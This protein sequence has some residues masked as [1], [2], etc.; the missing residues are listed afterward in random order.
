MSIPVLVSLYIFPPATI[1]SLLILLSIHSITLY[2]K[3]TYGEV[4]AGSPRHYSL[5]NC[6]VV[7]HSSS[8]PYPPR[9]LLKSSCEPAQI[10]LS[11]ALLEPF[12]IF[13]EEGIPYVYRTN[14]PYLP[15][16]Y[17]NS[18]FPVGFFYIPA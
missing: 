13:R 17:Q 10:R 5:P 14:I 6:K 16:F 4:G 1:P 3:R 8:I 18:S 15:S 11:K 2:I 12:L 9:P 7:S